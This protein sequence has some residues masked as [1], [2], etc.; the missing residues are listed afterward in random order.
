[1]Q[2]YTGVYTYLFCPAVYSSKEKKEG[3]W[4]GS[5]PKS[6]LMQAPVELAGSNGRQAI[7]CTA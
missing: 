6:T 1:M 3:A 2:L 4:S 7:V 5:M